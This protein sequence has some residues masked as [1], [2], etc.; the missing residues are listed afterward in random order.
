M[1][2]PSASSSRGDLLQKENTILD[3]LKNELMEPAFLSIQNFGSIVTEFFEF[4]LPY[5]ITIQ[6]TALNGKRIEILTAGPG[7][8]LHDSIMLKEMP[9]KRTLHQHN[10][11]E[12]MYVL[13]GTVKQH[14]EDHSILCHAGQCCIL[15]QSMK[16]REDT[17]TNFKV[18][19]LTL[20]PDFLTKLIQQDLILDSKK[21]LSNHQCKIY[22]FFQKNLK[23]E[24][25]KEFLDFF[26]IT[27]TSDF[28]PA[29]DQIFHTIVDETKDMLPG[30]WYMVSSMIIR[31][32]AYLE[33][34]IYYAMNQISLSGN[35]EEVLFN[36]ISLLLEANNGRISRNKLEEQMH[37]NAD[38]LNWII[39]KHTGKSL[40]K[41]GQTFYLQEAG[42]LLINTDLTIS[43]IIRE[44]GF[45]NR[46]Y[47]YRIFKEKYNMS[48]MDY[49]KIFASK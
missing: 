41:Y 31:F 46:S 21:T 36:Q 24:F 22:Q 19:F 9:S 6:T 42:N 27:D 14:F 39:K 26:P 35:R 5:T 12:I 34:P 25:E 38:Y 3:F 2:N 15:N 40:V 18:V 17:S 16:H 7:F 32:F 10:F 8:Y 43:E 23:Q 28:L 20:S 13:E 30:S 4:R 44:L 48:P 47:F 33:N 37:Y 11:I 45:S 1:T 49:R 29:I